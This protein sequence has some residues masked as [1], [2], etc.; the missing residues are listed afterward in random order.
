MF[1]W[2]NINNGV[3]VFHTDRPS[4]RSI[5]ASALERHGK[6]K[7]IYIIIP[8]RVSHTTATRI[9]THYSYGILFI[10]GICT[11][12]A[13]CCGGISREFFGLPRGHRMR[14]L[15]CMKGRYG[16]CV[17]VCNIII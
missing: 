10:P 4:H 1:D 13:T 17:C 2:T 16:T 9:N 6:Q 3:T 15:A 5:R 14:V 8:N 12:G 7:N 11:M